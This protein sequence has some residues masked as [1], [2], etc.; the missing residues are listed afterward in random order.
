[1]E[2]PSLT[3]A[4]AGSAA[5]FAPGAD[6][7]PRIDLAVTGRVVPLDMPQASEAKPKLP[8][9]SGMLRRAPSA[10]ADIPR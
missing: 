3:A 1:M 10:L 7:F 5:D 6:R 9:T 8:P 2:T 4:S